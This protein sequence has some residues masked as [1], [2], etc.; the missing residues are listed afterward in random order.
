[1]AAVSLACIAYSSKKS[2][3][4]IIAI[5]AI[6]SFAAPTEYWRELGTIAQGT[7]DSTADLRIYYWKCALRMFA[8]NPII[9]VGPGNFNWRIREYEDPEGRQGR[10]HGGHCAHSIYFT[11]LS[12]L[13]IVG[14][15][16]IACI[17]FS[18]WASSKLTKMLYFT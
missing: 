10:F 8:D 5:L 13:G 1:M 17:S 15:F 6:T 4:M 18:I 2:G 9:G 16:L 3:I 7:E 14:A 12:E 11:A